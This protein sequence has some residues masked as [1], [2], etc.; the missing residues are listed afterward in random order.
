MCWDDCRICSG[1]IGSARCAPPSAPVCTDNMYWVIETLLVQAGIPTYA[2]LRTAIGQI[3][4]QGQKTGPGAHIAY[5]PRSANGR[6]K[7]RTTA[8]HDHGRRQTV[9]PRRLLVL[10]LAP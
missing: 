2:S 9:A 6:V 1:V 4:S 5:R 8:T 10:P 3:D 7:R